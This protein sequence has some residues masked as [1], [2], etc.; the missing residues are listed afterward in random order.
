[1][2]ICDDDIFLVLL[3]YSACR[4]ELWLILVSEV[5]TLSNS[6]KE[7]FLLDITVLRPCDYGILWAR[8]LGSS[9]M[10]DISLEAVESS[11]VTLQRIKWSPLLGWACY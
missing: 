7:S 5:L 3:G 10:D 9:R 11:P 6:T 2:K 1:M 8:V 4:L